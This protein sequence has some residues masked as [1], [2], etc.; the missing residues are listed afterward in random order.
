MRKGEV[1]LQVNLQIIKNPR[2]PFNDTIFEQYSHDLFMAVKDAIETLEP[3]YINDFEWKSSL[4][5]NNGKI[6]EIKGYVHQGDI[7]ITERP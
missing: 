5:D 6:W 2:S 3:V 1:Q 4:K 7:K